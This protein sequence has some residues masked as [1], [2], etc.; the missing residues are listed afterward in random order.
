MPRTVAENAGIVLAFLYGADRNAQVTGPDIAAATSLAPQEIND[1]V[2]ILVENNYIEWQ[3]FLGTAP[4]AFG[5]VEITPRGRYQFERE[6]DAQHPASPVALQAPVP[7]DMAARPAAAAI[8]R[9][10]AMLIMLPRNQLVHRMGSKTRIGRL[11]RSE[12][13]PATA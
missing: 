5:Y 9:P 6:R 12:R 1:A 2:T 3:R 13:A 11:Y 8:D 4:W 7:T 10:V